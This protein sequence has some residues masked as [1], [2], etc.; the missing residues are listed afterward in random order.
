MTQEPKVDAAICQAAAYAALA[1]S[2]GDED[3]E[4]YWT[5]RVVRLSDAREAAQAAGTFDVLKGSPDHSG[6][7]SESI[8]RLERRA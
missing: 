4:A 8:A 3:R 7:L 2:N 6:R 1:R 5:E